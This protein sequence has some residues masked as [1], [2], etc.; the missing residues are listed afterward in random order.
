MPLLKKIPTLRRI[1]RIPAAALVFSFCV[2]VQ[3][4]AQQEQ[5][6]SLAVQAAKAI[7]KSMKG[8]TVVILNFSESDRPATML[9]LTLQ[10][11]FTDALVAAANGFTVTNLDELQSLEDEEKK[12][13]I[14]PEAFLDLGTQRC[15]VSETRAEAFVEGTVR[16]AGNELELVLL[17]LPTTMGETL[18]T[19]RIDFPRTAE[20]DKLQSQLRR[21]HGPAKAAVPAASPVKVKMDDDFAPGIPDAGE[22]GYTTPECTYCPT[23][24][25]STAAFR[26]R[27]Q[28]TV[29]VEVVVGVDGRAGSVA[30]LSGLP[31]GLNNEVINAV[32][33]VYKFLPAK[34]PDGKPAA[35]RMLFEIEFRIY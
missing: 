13:R 15:L 17:I 14:P 8:G 1:L 6:Y 10:R 26:D 31:C 18:F 29:V 33:K 21:E 35:V 32:Q 30:V 34:G 27:A 12:E 25:Y 5:I 2:A 4:H 24:R 11:E 28:G 7:S 19:G 9:D 22:K 23:P 16:P 3:S 20:L